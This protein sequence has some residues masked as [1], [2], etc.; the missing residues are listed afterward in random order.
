[1]NEYIV[2]ISN[3]WIATCKGLNKA[4]RIATRVARGVYVNIWQG[5][6]VIATVTKKQVVKA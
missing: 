4:I 5:D 2:R 1:M 6:K 3:Q